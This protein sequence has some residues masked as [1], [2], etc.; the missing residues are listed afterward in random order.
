MSFK[1]YS[2]SEDVSSSES[3]GES[4]MS[5][6]E[7]TVHQLTRSLTHAAHINGEPVVPR[8]VDAIS[9]LSPIVAAAWIYREADSDSFEPAYVH[10]SSTHRDVIDQLLERREMG[11]VDCSASRGPIPIRDIPGNAPDIRSASFVLSSEPEAHDRGLI[12]LCTRPLE[13]S[14]LLL[15]DTAVRLIAATEAGT[16]TSRQPA[17]RH[18]EILARLIGFIAHE[19][20]TPL[21]ALRGNVQLALMA[22]RKGNHERIPDRLE[23]ALNGVDTMSALVQSL[24]DV[25]RLERGNFTFNHTRS[26]LRSTIEA[27][28][29]QASRAA[30]VIPGRI[31]LSGLPS[32]EYMH[33]EGNL[34]RALANLLAAV[35]E[36]AD[37]SDDPIRINVEDEQGMLRLVISYQGSQF[38]P[39]DQI[40]LTQSLYESA[41]GSDRGSRD[42]LPLDLAFTRGIIAHHGGVVRFQK[43]ASPGVQELVIELPARSN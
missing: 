39:V 13:R 32:Y 21:T 5:S 15:L 1:H 26:D 19:L 10:A 17:H 38:L 27:A 35:T 16:H 43:P 42:E 9:S 34:T 8:F 31:E 23:A 28:I 29:E 14:R 20:R 2:F 37:Q 36:C 33:D 40:A 3:G 30:E 41:D 22:N 7:E 25:S 12:I 24:L 4:N 18:D 11:V 6:F